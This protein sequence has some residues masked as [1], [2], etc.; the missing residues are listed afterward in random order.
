MAKRVFIWVAHPKA[1]SL[2]AAMADAYADGVAGQISA[3]GG[4]ARVL[5]FDVTDRSAC[6]AA[7]N[8]LAQ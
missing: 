8:S 6:R 7:L 4:T 3:A 5:Q 2:C 1:G